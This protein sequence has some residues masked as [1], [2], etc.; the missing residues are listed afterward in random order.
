MAS[1]LRQKHENKR[2]GAKHDLK[3]AVEEPA[4]AT[5]EVDLFT[6]SNEH[7]PV[8]SKTNEPVNNVEPRQGTLATGPYSK[9]NFEK[10]LAQARENSKRYQLPE[11]QP[12]EFSSNGLEGDLEEEYALMQKMATTSLEESRPLRSS[13]FPSQKSINSRVEL[14][15]SFNAGK[16]LVYEDR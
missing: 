7:Q 11:F 9:E 13:K 15:K 16:C 3:H 5:P 6:C 4:R 12:P 10:F 8:N 2:A 14:L 1:Y